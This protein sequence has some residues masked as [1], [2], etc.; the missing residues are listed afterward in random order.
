MGV[1]I[2]GFW[3]DER[4]YWTLIT[5]HDCT[6]HFT[7]THTRAPTSVHSHVFTSRCSV[8]ASNGGRSP[9]SGFPNYPRAQLPASQSNNSRQLN[10][11]SLT[12]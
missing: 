7:V 9:F 8:A 10:L 12:D 11:S 6:L 5:A 4:I 3:I 2:D 1:P